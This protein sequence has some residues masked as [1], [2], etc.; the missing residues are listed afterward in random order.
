MRTEDSKK[1]FNEIK[2]FWPFL[3]VSQ[4]CRCVHKFSILKQPHVRSPAFSDFI[5]GRGFPL[6]HDHRHHLKSKGA[7]KKIQLNFGMKRIQLAFQ[8]E[9]TRFLN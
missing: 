2:L 9:S 8:N 6:H 3:F 5:I 7:V 1:M 4:L